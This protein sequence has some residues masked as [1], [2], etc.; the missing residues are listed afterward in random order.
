MKQEEENG[1]M[2][3]FYNLSKIMKLMRFIL[4]I[5]GTSKQHDRMPQKDFYPSFK[6]L[7]GF[8]AYFACILIGILTK[9]LVDPYYEPLLWFILNIP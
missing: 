3:I 2:G 4:I 5:D 1:E 6:G 9:F 7:G 8:K